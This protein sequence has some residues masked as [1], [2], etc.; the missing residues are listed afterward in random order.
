MSQAPPGNR[1]VEAGGHRL[2]YRWIAGK[3]DRPALA[4]LHEGLGSVAMWK[5]FPDDLAKRTG[6]PALVYSR[7][8]YG[9]S[10]GGSAPFQPDYMHRE[11][12]IALP[13]LLGAL[14]VADPVLIGHSDGASIAL[15][16]AGEGTVNAQALILEAPHVFVEDINIS[17]IQA[18][19][20]TFETTD[21]KARLGRYHR[22]PE[23]SFRAWNDAWLN[24][25]FRAWNIE[26]ILAAT[27]C[28]VLVI[29][30]EDDPYGT[31]AQT[32]AIARQAGGA[33]RIE[34]L[35]DCGHAPHRD[36]RE[37]TLAAMAGFI[38]KL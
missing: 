1:F 16:A 6:C 22:D 36:Q 32:E 33:C 4:F 34:L 28:P 9:W 14:K 18:V 8:G 37:K 13:E 20:E 26:N 27:R 29:Q 11:A 10:D 30:G 31:A 35:A 25:A 2:E 17:S 24:P 5:D 23:A 38:E 21:L 7:R 12:R 19:R 3:A 15:I